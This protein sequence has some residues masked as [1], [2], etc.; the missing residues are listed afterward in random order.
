MATRFRS[1][2]VTV[3]VVE[4]R[5]VEH[6]AFGEAGV[7]ERHPEIIRVDGLVSR[8][9]NVGNRR[10]FGNEDDEYVAF[11]F[12]GD[13]FKKA[14]LEERADGFRGPVAVYF[15]ANLDGQIVENRAR[16]NTLKSFQANFL[17]HEK[18]LRRSFAGQDKQKKQL[19]K[20]TG[21]N[22]FHANYFCCV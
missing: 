21:A 19:K 12:D 3:L 9:F 15:V 4:E 18:I 20:N 17:D 7:S 11:A 13:V 6:P 16:R 22:T 8:K 5:A 1:S 2:G 10:A 14:R